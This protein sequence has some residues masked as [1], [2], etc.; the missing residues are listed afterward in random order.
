MAKVGRNPFERKSNDIPISFTSRGIEVNSRKM[1]DKNQI[2]EQ[3]P[4]EKSA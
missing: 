4:E 1:L 2:P 3:F